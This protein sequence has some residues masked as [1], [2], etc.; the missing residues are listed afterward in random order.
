MANAFN[1]MFREPPRF[2]LPMEMPS[3]AEDSTRTQ[4][5][6]EAS[7]K[8]SSN[9]VTASRAASSSIRAVDT[10]PSKPPALVEAPV[11][12]AGDS[13]GL[14]TSL[15]SYLVSTKKTIASRN[16]NCFFRGLPIRNYPQAN[17]DAERR[18]GPTSSPRPVGGPIL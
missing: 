3:M 6:A 16:S 14:V 18:L 15:K 5:P 4:L 17:S 9:T 7:L 11:L 2:M 12:I 13:L 10:T 8:P 1:K